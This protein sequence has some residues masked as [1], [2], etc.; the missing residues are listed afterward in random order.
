MRSYT[1]KP[2]NNIRTTKEPVV[3]ET[4]CFEATR[5]N[6]LAAARSLLAGKVWVGKMLDGQ[7]LEIWDDLGQ[8]V[9]TGWLADD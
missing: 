2:R 6:A 4:A 7:Q 5:A 8:M 1:I 3:H 9:A